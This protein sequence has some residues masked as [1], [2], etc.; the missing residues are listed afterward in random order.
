MAK[1]ASG[2]PMKPGD[3]VVV[4][5]GVWDST[6]PE[7]RPDGLILEAF[8]PDHKNPDQATVLFCNGAM[9]KFHKS[10]LTILKTKE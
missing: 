4:N 10:Q 8:G 9:L 7:G 6:M 2:G 3:Y 1:C 5:D